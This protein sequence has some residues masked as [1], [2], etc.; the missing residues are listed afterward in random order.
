MRCKK[1]FWLALLAMLFVSGIAHAQPS[2]PSF[3]YVNVDPSGA[4]VN[5]TPNQ[6]NFTNNV[7]WG[8]ENGVWVKV[9]TGGSVTS[10]SGPSIFTWANPTTAAVASLNS[11]AANLFLGSPNGS[12]GTPTFRGLVVADLPTGIPNANLANPATTVN[13]QTCTL[14]STCTVPGTAA[15]GGTTGDLVD[16]TSAT[17]IGDSGIAAANVVTLAGTQALTNKT[18]D[19][20]SP[21]T[22]AFVDPTS[23]IQT[24]LNAKG[25]R[26]KSCVVITGDPGAASPVLA[27]DNS[28]PVACSNDLGS[29]WTITSVSCWAN[30]GTPTVTPILTGGSGT[31]ILTGALTCGAASWAA[32]TLNG[33]PT[34]NSFSAGATCSSTPCSIDANMTSAGG[35][36]KYIVVK[37]VGTY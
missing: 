4:C 31:S 8:C 36:A 14:G 27:N 15:G 33:T 9:N 25:I 26:Q 24:Q 16:Y 37:I 20:V 23:S 13:G 35:T 18:L 17:A 11:Q 22:M 7:E 6:Y 32:G 30:A 5:T 29:A 21:T 19:G 34:V 10:V 1:V 2:A 12:S 3:R 28:A